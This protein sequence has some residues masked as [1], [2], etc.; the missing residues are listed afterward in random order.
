MQK[1]KVIIWAVTV[2]LIIAVSNIPIV[3]FF[4]SF[5]TGNLSMM[6]L[7]YHYIS[8]K[9]GFS[10]WSRTGS[11]DVLSQFEAYQKRYPEDTV[12]YRNFQIKPWQFWR[13]YEYTEI[14]YRLPYQPMPPNVS[15][16]DIVK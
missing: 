1:K 16:V 12:L 2:L 10:V 6:N 13:I 8:Q 11:E 4:I 15:K 9:G 3:S 7:D 5:F 14:S